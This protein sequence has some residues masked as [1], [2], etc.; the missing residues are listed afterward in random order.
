MGSVMDEKAR[1][2]Q[3]CFEDLKRQTGISTDTKVFFHVDEEQ[4]KRIKKACL[5]NNPFPG[6][7]KAVLLS[8]RLKAVKRLFE[9]EN[10]LQTGPAAAVLALDAVQAKEI[11][12]IRNGL[13]PDAG[14]PVYCD[15]GLAGLQV[16]R[17]Y[18][19]AYEGN[20]SFIKSR[21]D[22][23]I[24]VDNALN[25]SFYKYKTKDN[26]Y[27]SAHVYYESQK[28]KM[29]ET[30]GITKDPDKFV[31]G[32]MAADKKTTADA[33]LKW[34]ATDLEEAAFDHGA[35]GCMLRD[36][37]EWEE[38]EVGKA[39]CHMPLYRFTKTADT[40]VKSFGKCDPD[41]GPLSGMKVL[42]LTH[43]IA[44]PACTRLLAEQGADVLM[45]RRGD[46]IN[47]E[48]AMLELDGWAGKNSIQLDFN[49]ESQL[50]KAKELVKE[51]DIVISSYQNGA[52]DHFGLSETDIHKLNPKVIYGSLLCFSDTV[53]KH[54]P[55]W[56]PCAEDITGLSIRNGSKETPVNLNGVPLD[57]IPGMILFGG[58]MKALKLQ[59]TEGGSYTV[60]GSL[61]RGGYW[62][63]QCTDLWESVENGKNNKVETAQTLDEVDIIS[64]ELRYNM[65]L[66][67]WNSI[68][69]KI[70]DTAVGD[71]YFPAPATYVKGQGKYIM[72]N[73]HFTDG[74]TGFQE[75]GEEQKMNQKYEPLFTPWKIG[76][77]EIKNRI[78]L[79]SMGGTNLFGW[80]EKHHFDKE[81]ANFILEVA[82]NNT[83]LILPGCQPVYN[84]MFGQWLYKND[85]MYRD[86]AEWMPRFHKTGAKLFVQ[87]TAGFGRSFTISEMMENLYTNKALRVLSKP[88][89]DL[90]KITASA[91]P[92]P[93]RW[94]DKV[95][96][97]EMTVEEIHEFVEAFA[98]TAKKLQDAGVDGVEIHAVHE[99]YLLDQFTLKYVNK[100][101][102]E[103]GG[104][105]EN[106]Y[107]FAVEIVQAIKK[108]CGKDFP[109]S[110]RY[111]VISKTKGFREGALPY[112][113]Y[114]EAG[115][116]M[117]ESERAV[118]YLQDA[119]YDMLNCDNGTY[120]AWY[121]AHPPIYMPENCNLADVAHI[122]KFVDIP[123]VCAGRLNPQDAANAVAKGEIDGAG[124]A[125]PF[126]ADR[127]WVTKLMNNQ[128]EEIR[129]CILCH[130]GC[131]N[132]CHYKGVP[133]DQELSDSLHLARC[134]VNAETMQTDK[135]YIQKAKSAK[136]VIIIGGGI[137][138]MEAARVLKLR[139][140]EPVIYEK[141]DVLG[142]TFIP[143]SAESYKGKLRDLLTWYRLQMKE[144]NIEIHLNTEVKDLSQFEGLEIFV[145]TGST[146]RVLSKVPGNEK[147]IEACEFLN[148]AEVG[149]TVAVIGGGLTGSEIAYEL[150]LQGKKPVIVEMK[151]DLVSQKGVCLANSSYL[152]EW[153][154]LHKI[155]VYLETV[156]KEVKDG[157]I[158][159]TT[160]DGD[161]EIP[162]DSVISSAGYISK[163][164]VEE[165]KNVHLVGDCKQIGN[166][167]T[168]IWRAYEVG[169]MI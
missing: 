58:I 147:M 159:C 44:G 123:V 92:A 94:S 47:Q 36:R 124:F 74:N 141:S 12:N 144:M 86:L 78:V 154:A 71:V 10:V 39:V 106:R 11:G 169:M 20:K 85:K 13:E 98:K 112:E 97:R 135:H 130:S 41:K 165:S 73:M 42:D 48:Q 79:T 139:G 54:R 51:A 25:G 115:R 149:E 125:R 134:A 151:D 7:L 53:W 128:E 102:D 90:D 167:R 160:K 17:L 81:G 18:M 59:I 110:L 37:K 114:I 2:A 29:M 22:S 158:I 163:P 126:L 45:I 6:V 34:N 99:G 117:E 100:R 32:S 157:A 109:V 14:G 19:S 23:A 101:T 83:G 143:A 166:L 150:A 156:L 52:L 113:D 80:M 43:I 57:Y 82:K 75:D 31:F 35:C 129:P 153:F 69:Y 146:A 120:D 152:R 28:R 119:G 64:S 1:Q 33:I 95:P 49:N 72:S 103:Y 77:C 89:M 116:D 70:T 21:Y 60:T 50:A 96:S 9:S 155:P 107:R 3:L 88:F 118:K 127:A 111:S 15:V 105:F 122:K 46:Y 40:P 84:P 65:D 93:N 87:L 161:L 5:Y 24:R 104:S 162:C 131:F 55:G 140:H 133:N 4:E 62:L 138:G 68:L 91:S 137:G 136:K 76:N 63:H 145:A 30:L 61:T 168:V 8:L 67:S 142:G 121:W 66:K 148:G 27:F 108:V 26:R 38:M 56:A 132:M 16:I 164:L